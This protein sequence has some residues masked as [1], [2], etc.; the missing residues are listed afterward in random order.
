MNP[1]ALAMLVELR[2]VSVGG[3]KL[4]LA[5]S[6]FIPA[7][8]NISVINQ[9]VGI[10]KDVGSNLSLMSFSVFSSSSSLSSSFF[11]KMTCRCR[12]PRP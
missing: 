12:L 10:S 3:F 2:Y 5:A 11:F 1:S 4:Q 6:L 8:L 7:F 9:K